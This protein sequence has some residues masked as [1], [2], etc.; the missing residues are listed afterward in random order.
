MMTLDRTVI[1]RRAGFTLIELL[2]VI[3]II[4]LLLGILLP[5][6][7][8]AREA[9]HS[10]VCQANLRSI[11]QAQGA[12][13]TEHNG[14]LAGAPGNTARELFNDSRATSGDAPE[15]NGLATQPWDWAGPLAY[16]GYIGDAPVPK[17]RYERFGYL[18]GS[19]GIENPEAGGSGPFGMLNCPSQR[20]LAAPYFG[21]NT[22][23]L[24][25]TRE[26][27]V[28][29]AFSYTSS[30]DMLWYGGSSASRP[31]WATDQF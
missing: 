27:P 2:V 1:G 11:A 4:G 3:S 24:V 18:N 26:F 23:A 20:V 6:L 8:A 7:A 22:T 29:V 9:A 25:G 13:Y 15:V 16:G 19:G 14:D 21:S 5:S 30:R 10:V 28:T 12:Y 31:R 17:W